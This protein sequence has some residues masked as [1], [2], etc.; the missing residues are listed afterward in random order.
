MSSIKKLFSKKTQKVL[1]G[2][3]LSTVASGGLE[4][5][6]F[7]RSTEKEK[8][9]FEPFVDFSSTKNFARYGSA[10]K[11]YDDSIGYII[12]QYPYDGSL[13]EKANWYISSSYF[14]TYIF[15]NEYPRTTGYINHGIDYGTL[16]GGTNG[17]SGSTKQ[18]YISFK[19]G[20]HT[21]SAGMIGS[22]LSV[23]F[24]GSNYYDTGSSRVSNLNLD[25]TNGNTVEFWFKKNGFT[26]GSESPRQ[27]FLDVWNSAS[28]ASTAYT[29]FR[30]ECDFTASSQQF[31]I[32]YTDNSGNGFNETATMGFLGQDLNLTSST[33][34]HY[35]ISI[36]CTPTDDVQAQL[37]VNGQLNHTI[38]SSVCPTFP[39]PS[40]SMLGWIGAL[41]T[42]SAGTDG[43][44]GFAKLSG[45]LDEFRFWKVRRTDTQIG[46]YWFS[47]VGAG[48]NTDTSNTDLG[49]YYKFN[50]G[51]V[52][53]TEINALDAKVLDY[54]G[55]VTNGAWAGYATG[56]RSTNSAI[57]ESS[58]SLSE[59]K[60]PI[61]YRTNPAVES[62]ISAK[63]KLGLDYD[64]RNNSGIY[65]SLPEW[66]TGDEAELNSGNIKS[67]VQ[68]IGSY[69]DSLYL[70]IE[71]VPKLK[72]IQY[73]S[74]S[75]KPIP[76]TNR[77]L[78]SVGLYAPEIFADAN[79]LEYYA[80]RDDYRKFSE[81]I[82]DVKNKIYENIY[83]NIVYIFK[84]K[85]TEK[86]F[87]NLI[88]CYG[89]DEPLVKINLYAD[90]LAYQLR[91]NARSSVARKKFIDFNN[92]DRFDSS[93]YQQ[94]ASSNLNT[95]NFIT[96]SSDMSFIPN[97][98]EAEVI[99]P[100]KLGIASPLY[101]S[102]DF[103]TCSLFGC[104]TP[105]SDQADMTWATPDVS[106]FQVQAV[107]DAIEGSDVYFKLTSSAGG[108]IPT[109]TSSIFKDVYNDT[110]WNFAVRV[111][112]ISV[113]PPAISG[114]GGIAC[115]VEFVG[116]NSILDNVENSFYLSASIPVAD[117]N[118]FLSSSKRIYVGA[119]RVNFT[120][121]LVAI[122]QQTDAKI[123]SVRYWI[124]NLPNETIEAHSK[125]A[126]SIGTLEPHQ[127]AYL[128]KN[129][130]PYF[131]AI[132]VPQIKTLALNWSFDNV[133]G[134]GDSSTGSPTLSDATF[135]V[136]D[137][138]SG[139]LATTSSYGW[140]GPVVNMQHTGKGDFFLSFDTGSVSRE[141]VYTAKL[142]PPEV[143]NSS[144]MV[145]IRTQ[146]DDLFTRETRPIDY[147][148]A[149]EKSQAAIIS[150]EMI[151]WFSTIKDFNFLIGNPVN[152]YRQNYKPMEKLRERYFETIGNTINFEKFVEY[153]KWID[154]AL[155]V[156]LSQ[157]VP[158][159]ANF[160]EKVRLL[161]EDHILER[162]KYWSKFPTL[163]MKI[164]DPEAG[165]RGIVEGLYPWGRGHA[166]I[167]MA[168]D[169][170]C[171]WAHDRAER[172]VFPSGDTSIDNQRDIY[173]EADDFRATA[174]GP[175]L[176][177]IDGVQ[178]EGST[179][180]LRN[181]TQPYRFALATMP[182][183]H[184]G[185]NFPKAKTVEY[186]HES[187]KFG[188]SEQ[189][190]IAAASIAHEEDCNDVVPQSII[191]NRLECKVTNTADTNGYLSGKGTLF[192]PF[193]LFSSSVESGYVSD[194]ATNFRTKTEIDN[195]HDDIYGDD[196][197]I[198]A[199]GPFT[200]NHVGGRQH[201][202]VNVN[203]SSAT[204]TLTRPEA[205]NLD[206]QPVSNIKSIAYGFKIPLP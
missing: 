90:N 37:Y 45:S 23:T 147:F 125:D 81:K 199:Q 71:A 30:I 124:S 120:G 8:S 185:S 141:Y 177:T 155:S 198:P 163:E 129:T 204:T 62:F 32:V 80:S 179:Y 48:S 201:R 127:S 133:T 20:P 183:I 131:E 150:E 6:D 46:R 95:R 18:E 33:W 122:D 55:R 41:G 196:K 42:S 83:N 146:D 191:K 176:S 53:T 101:F 137:M 169:D 117:G 152:R 128:T 103:A 197:G 100:P 205:W 154:D 203:T 166:P 79:A 24:T 15:E 35:A 2:R 192:A 123:S 195:Y 78:E 50:E 65:S 182:E 27:V 151:K 51:I 138:S 145:E 202:H 174:V 63:R 44:L 59:F 119:E 36:K 13:K 200:E 11:Y 167:P 1:S 170:N 34:N 3:S 5:P 136:E 111:S 190:K 77:F 107:R 186:T 157:L 89:I 97:T 60:D 153:F 61:L 162:N 140:L 161:I 178:Y 188:S 165:A 110:R 159:S 189:L 171:F 49:F 38:T 72:D 17:Y 91:D 121:S 94:T 181:F 54:S 25:R 180:A 47:Q 87:R 156:M 149:I 98:M 143:L 175:T 4:S 73:S 99:F 144:D 142:S 130:V 116:Y 84:S 19:G 21:A 69:F 64:F 92:T 118:T 105:L 56:S 75:Q 104:H 112:P 172:S 10:E 173:K 164:D 14:D 96:A 52:D 7:L 76:F 57:V 132:E 102:T 85:G 31:N 134:S 158:A 194:V 193:S 43:A 168:Q 58:A 108:V 114:S 39:D 29:R 68:I 22:P 26:G 139:S 12:N 206:F 16:A 74:G 9:K 40:G 86:S 109:L 70:Q 148:Y 184:G 160:A 187:L 88:R 82:G 93:V 28:F 126:S 135:L 67:L 66:I 106:N 115:L 113:A